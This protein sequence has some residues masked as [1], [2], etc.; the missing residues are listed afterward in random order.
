MPLIKAADPP[1]QQYVNNKDVLEKDQTESGKCLFD[2]NCNALLKLIG[3]VCL[4]AP[5]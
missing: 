4:L 2:A 5:F 3:R 1:L